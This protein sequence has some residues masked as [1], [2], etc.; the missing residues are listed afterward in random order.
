MTRELPK[1]EWH[2]LDDESRTFFETVHEQD[3]AVFVAERDGEIVGHMAVIRAP[4]FERWWVAPAQFGNAGVTR[5]L[6]RA[7]TEKARDWAPN[8]VIAHG[9]EQMVETLK[10]LGGDWLPVHTAMVPL[11]AKEAE[12]RPQ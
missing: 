3:I 1:A 11:H 6:L 2:R 10:R 7:G 4:F 9:N 5:G 8:W 12:C